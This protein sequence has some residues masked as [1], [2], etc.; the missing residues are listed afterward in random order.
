MEVLAIVYRMLAPVAEVLEV[1]VVLVTLMVAQE[2]V[3]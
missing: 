1:S 3:E 2:E